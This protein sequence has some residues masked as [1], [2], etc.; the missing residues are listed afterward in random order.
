M[1]IVPPYI[2]EP[3]LSHQFPVEVVVAVTVVAEV[4][5]V[6]VI[7]EAEV[8]VVVVVIGV[9]VKV[10][11]EVVVVVLPAQD[12]SSIETTIRK[13]TPITIILLFISYLPFD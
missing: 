4:V 10:V 5:D 13:L 1:V 7:V 12:A 11:V 9:V 3:R 2:G 6:V 8:V